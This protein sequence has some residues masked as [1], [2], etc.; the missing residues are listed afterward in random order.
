MGDARFDPPYS[1]VRDA[2]DRKAAIGALTDAEVLAALGGAS[3]ERDAYL[4]NVLTTEALNRHRRLVALF[5]AVTYGSAAFILPR[6]LLQFVFASPQTDPSE[7]LRLLLTLALL[8]GSGTV[9][10]V[11]YLRAQ[12]LASTE[13]F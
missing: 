12:R 10:L 2:T 11:A 4:A 5:A 6:I 1:R 9:A 7:L 3:R 8:F 13:S